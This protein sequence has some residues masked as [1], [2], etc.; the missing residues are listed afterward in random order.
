MD[1]QPT[2]PPTIAHRI[3]SRN[4]A[5]KAFMVGRW[6]THPLNYELVNA[7]LPLDVELS[8]S[9][10]LIAVIAP[11]EWDIFWW[12]IYPIAPLLG[13]FGGSYIQPVKK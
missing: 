4:K 1:R 6:T 10:P 12:F 3:P 13:Y 2:I 7:G 5:D 8:T 11:L 9:W